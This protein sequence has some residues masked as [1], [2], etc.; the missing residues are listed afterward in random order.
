MSKYPS[1]LRYILKGNEGGANNYTRHVVLP[2]D[3]RLKDMVAFFHNRVYN[4]T[5]K[6][7]WFAN[8]Q[9]KYLCFKA[10]E[11]IAFGRFFC[12]LALLLANNIIFDYRHKAHGQHSGCLCAFLYIPQAEGI[13]QK[14]KRG[15]QTW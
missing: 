15:E 12:F 4:T 6:Y 2:K 11:G 13:C 8:R 3:K 14:N 9:T 5:I 7:L 10:S 1:Q